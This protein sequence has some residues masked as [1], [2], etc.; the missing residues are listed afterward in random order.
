MPK[1][2][3]APDR[4]PLLEH[5]GTTIEAYQHHGFSIPDR[6][7]R[8]SSRILYAARDENNERHWRASLDEMQALIDRGF[9][10]TTSG[11]SW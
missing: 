10:T 11:T 2:P 4:L 7:P 8:P 5:N 9:T 1:A 6:G 3:P